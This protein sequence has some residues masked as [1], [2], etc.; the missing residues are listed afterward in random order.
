MIFS[1][2]S[3][4][5]HYTSARMATPKQR[6]PRNLVPGV[7]A[8]AQY[9]LRNARQLLLTPTEPNRRRGVCAVCDKIKGSS[10]AVDVFAHLGRWI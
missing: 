8:F 4:V 5:W 10:D 9:F 7:S 2:G 3:G 1:F 6:G